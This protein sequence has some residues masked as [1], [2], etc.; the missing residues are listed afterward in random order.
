VFCHLNIVIYNNLR[1]LG[2]VTYIAVTW[3]QSTD[4]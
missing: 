4:E 2:F 3:R 1:H